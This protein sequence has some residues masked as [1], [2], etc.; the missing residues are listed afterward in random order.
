MRKWTLAVAL[1]F[2]VA[3]GLQPQRAAAQAADDSLEA[4]A[5]EM[6]QTPADHG[7]L[8]EHFRAKAAEA[9]AAASRHKSMG[10]VYGGGKQGTRVANFHCKRISKREASI[11]ASYDEMAKI[12]EAEARKPK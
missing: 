5:I 6:A 12:H 7:A 8:A 9:R 3:V 2:I 11:A 10:K 4:H 1:A